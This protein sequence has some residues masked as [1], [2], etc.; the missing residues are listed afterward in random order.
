MYINEYGER[1]ADWYEV[2]RF[3]PLSEDPTGSKSEGLTTH[4]K[5]HKQAEKARAEALKS[6]KY[7]AVYIDHIAENSGIID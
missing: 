2:K 1:E 4:H 7:E 3:L 6:G 5:T